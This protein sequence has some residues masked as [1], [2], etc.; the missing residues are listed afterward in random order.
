MP[1]HSYGK[2]TQKKL[3]PLVTEGS[4]RWNQ[5]TRVQISICEYALS[6]NR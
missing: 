1:N 2:L 6:G 3:S 4:K 5:S